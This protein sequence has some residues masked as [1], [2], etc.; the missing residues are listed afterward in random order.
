MDGM[1]GVMVESINRIA[2]VMAW[3]LDI[4]LNEDEMICFQLPSL[5]FGA[6]YV[7]LS[8]WAGLL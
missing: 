4:A 7:F 8:L 1:E 5:L 2:R 6:R 3:A